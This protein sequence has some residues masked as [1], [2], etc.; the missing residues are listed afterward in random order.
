MLKI[1]VITVCYNE[2]DRLKK[3]IE[4]VCGQ[5][6]PRI[7]YLIVDGASTDGTPDM[8]EKYL[9]NTDKNILFYSEKDYGI[10]NAMNRGIARAS[11]DYICFIN[12]GDRFYN[13]TVIADVV[14]YIRDMDTIY[15]GKACLVYADGLMQIQDF[16]GKGLEFYKGH[17]PCHQSIFSPRDALVNHH[18]TE[19]YKIRADF[20][21]FLY[22]LRSGYKC[23]GL[24]II[25]S[26]YD[27]N[28]ASSRIKNNGLLQQEGKA[29]LQGYQE[30][31]VKEGGADS[32]GA[33]AGVEEDLRKYKYL[34]ILMNSW[35]AL[36]QKNVSIA[37]YFKAKKYNHV[38]IYGMGHMGLRLLDELKSCGITV[39]YVIDKDK[40][41][42]CAGVKLVSP[43]EKLDETDA[44]I[45][46]AVDSYYEIERKLSGR[47]TCPVISLEDVI[48]D[49]CEEMGCFYVGR[50]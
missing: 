41:C 17:M 18:F 50:Y 2:K 22:S 33:Q 43:D 36:K 29:I 24:P 42:L 46:T 26:Y 21:W 15:F 37:R 39:D 14:S 48:Y 47:V 16:T 38:A 23:K 35:F 19:T 7:E 9:M 45:V 12:A 11:G 5:T 28:G 13:E 30:K 20:E 25:I 32:M 3:T 4:S 1:T 44:V 40:D 34:F 8:L 49:V 6:Y 10:Y 27:V 31:A